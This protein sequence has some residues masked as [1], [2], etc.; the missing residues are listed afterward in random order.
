MIK[1]KIPKI[2]FFVCLTGSI[3]F[4][5]PAHAVNI[6]HGGYGQVLIYPYYTAKNGNVTLLTIAND[7][8]DAK[9]V[10]IRLLESK[11]GLPALYFNIYLA[12][13]D[14][15]VGSVQNEEGIVTLKT[16]D[17]SCTVPY[18]Y[19]DGGIPVDGG[20]Y[21]KSNPETYEGFLP[22]SEGHIEVIDMGLIQK[23]SDSEGYITLVDGK[24]VDCDAILRAWAWPDNTDPDTRGYW[25]MNP[26]TDMS[27]PSG[28][29]FGDAAIVNASKGTLHS[30]EAIA[31]NGFAQSIAAND[32]LHTEPRFRTPNLNSGDISTAYVTLD[33]GG[34]TSWSFA[35]GVDAVS[36]VLMQESIANQ[37]ITGDSVGAATDWVVTFP[38]KPF[39][40][41]PNFSGS[42]QVLAP[43]TSLWNGSGACEEVLLNTAD[44][45][46]LE[47][48]NSTNVVAFGPYG[49]VVL[50]DGFEQLGLNDIEL[51]TPGYNWARLGLNDYSWDKD[52][53]EIV[54]CNKAGVGSECFSRDPLG[55]LQGL[56]VVGF[57]M[58]RYTN[59]LGGLLQHRT[60][61][62]LG[63]N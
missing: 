14:T 38:T 26:T 17:T 47:L 23:G 10:K 32:L 21:A 39:Y 28:G 16:S 9:A 58:Q 63:Q 18:V 61:R 51:L 56:P 3:G 41:Y 6:N 46:R 30:Y 7:S 54:D 1:N 13:K 27:N 55:N 43:F 33:N 36:Y 2:A 12:A 8:E 24:P 44:S 62:K 53:N 20:P 49:E 42:N 4:S 60:T 19:R 40:V 57:G 11:I 45:G 37:Y 59:G 25:L 35:R 52:E 5:N 50:T 15:W 31:I 34:N 29:L 22:M 48:C